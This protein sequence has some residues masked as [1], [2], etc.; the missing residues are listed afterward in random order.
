MDYAF[1][2]MGLQDIE[3]KACVQLISF[4]FYFSINFLFAIRD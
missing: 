4:K 1:V 3:L 2:F